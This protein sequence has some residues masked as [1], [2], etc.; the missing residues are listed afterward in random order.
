MKNM[1]E[2]IFLKFFVWF[3]NESWNILA[4]ISRNST[5]AGVLIKSTLKNR[6]PNTYEMSVK[7]SQNSEKLRVEAYPFCK[8][9]KGAKTVFLSR[10]EGRKAWE[11]WLEL[12]LEQ[13]W[14]TIWAEAYPSWTRG[15]LK[16]VARLYCGPTRQSHLPLTSTRRCV[17]GHL[18]S[19]HMRA[20]RLM[21][22]AV[23]LKALLQ[24][25]GRQ[26]QALSN[27]F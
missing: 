11:G 12:F 20:K 19:N 6:I 23:S 25:I 3:F 13:L 18:P 14:K 8:K 9:A 27:T 22:K 1:L 21:L 4:D 15:A 5:T 24:A 16:Y 7:I 17:E 2:N 26:R 10:V